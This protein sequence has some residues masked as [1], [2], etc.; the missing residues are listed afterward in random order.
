[1]SAVDKPKR[2][3]GEEDELAEF[4]RARLVGMYSHTFS[5]LRS[6]SAQH[7]FCCSDRSCLIHFCFKLLPFL[8]LTPSQLL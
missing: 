1:M 2:G 3:S 6:P 7:E 4:I 8:M 5:E